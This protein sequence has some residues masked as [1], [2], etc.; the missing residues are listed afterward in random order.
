MDHLVLRPLHPDPGFVYGAAEMSFSALPL[1]IP[2]NGAIYTLGRAGGAGGTIILAVYGYWLREKG[3]AS[4]RWMRVVRL[5]NSI[6]YA[7]S[8]IFV[9]AML[10]VGAE[11]LYSANIELSAGYRALLRLADILEGHGGAFMSFFFL[12]GFFETSL[13]SILGAWNGVSLMFADFWG[14]IRKI[15]EDDPRRRF[16]GKYYRSYFSG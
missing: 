7:V 4:G 3:W 12:I 6:A 5:D 9:V 11:L 13:S 14:E 2:D 16:D 8:G 10:V 15:H 1:V